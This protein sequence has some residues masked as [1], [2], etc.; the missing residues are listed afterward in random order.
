MS[1]GYSFEYFVANTGHSKQNA[2]RW[3]EDFWETS[4]KCLISH[5][6]WLTSNPPSPTRP[7]SD[8]RSMEVIPKHVKISTWKPNI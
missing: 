1:Q 2:Y 8:L 7:S 6:L 4:A 5:L 3:L